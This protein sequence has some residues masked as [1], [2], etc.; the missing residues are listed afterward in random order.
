MSTISE[1]LAVSLKLETGVSMDACNYLNAMTAISNES[2][3]EFET[4]VR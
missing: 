2:I 4:A 1:T 3:V